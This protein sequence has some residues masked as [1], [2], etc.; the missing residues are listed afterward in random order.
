VCDN[1]SQDETRAVVAGFADPRIRYVRNAENLGMVGN[2][3]RCLAE[4]RGELIANLCDDDLML[5]DRL[6]RQVAIFDAHPETGVVHGD[7]EMIDEG[8]RATGTWAA[9]EFE[10]HE[11]L[12]VLVRM[13]NFLVYRPARSTGAC[14]R[15]SADTR[16]AIDRGRLDLWLRAA[17]E[18]ASGIRRA[19]RR[20]V[21]PPRGSG[22]HEDRRPIEIA[23]VERALEA[24]VERRCCGWFRGRRRRA[25]RAGAPRRPAGGARPSVAWAG[26]A[27]ADR[28]LAGRRRI[29]LTSFGYNDSGGGTIVPRYLSKSSSG[30]AGT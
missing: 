13:H 23:E 27:G 28:G 2:W 14:S 5:P 26:G 11:L 19:A 15:R 4:A 12:H 25:G 16:R 3:N 17:A 18:F 29:M 7:A 8:G 1:A 6:A 21:S 9:G 24:T 22:S 10:P 30:E 20:A